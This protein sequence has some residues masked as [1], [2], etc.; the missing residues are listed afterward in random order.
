M[1]LDPSEHSDF[2]W[3]INAIAA[4]FELVDAGALPARGRRED[5]A[6]LCR[7]LIGPESRWITGTA[8]NVDG[9]HHL[10]RGPDFTEFAEALP[11]RAVLDGEVPAKQ[12]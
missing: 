1:R 12:S 8:I 5:V 10:R 11:G 7:F 4:D 2:P 6:D 9:G 3:R